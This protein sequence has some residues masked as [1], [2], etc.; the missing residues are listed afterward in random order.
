MAETLFSLV[1]G[2]VSKIRRVPFTLI[3]GVEVTCGVR[4]LLDADDD[5]IDTAARAAA[6]ARGVP[7]PKRGEPI[8]DRW[9]RLFSLLFA[10]VAVSADPDAPVS[11]DP[12]LFF[13]GGVEQIQHH[14]DRERIAY[15]FSMQEQW[16]ALIAPR[17]RGLNRDQFMQAVYT[18][19]MATTGEDDLPFWRWHPALQES[20]L[21]TTASLLIGSAVIKSAYGSDSGTSSTSSSQASSEAG[22]NLTRDEALRLIDDALIRGDAHVASS[23]AGAVHDVE[24]PEHA[25]QREGRGADNPRPRR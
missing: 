11:D 24:L 16:Q 5:A 14:L 7:E 25:A 21:V 13:D 8:Y 22:V 3:S 15:L 6:V 9:V 2:G 1:A 10:C 20:Y 18:H 4:I 23:G 19:A 12:P 17:Q